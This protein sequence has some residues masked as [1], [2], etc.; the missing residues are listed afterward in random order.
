MA[1]RC[2]L[3][4]G[5]DSSDTLSSSSGSSN[6]ERSVGCDVGI[7]FV[8]ERAAALGGWRRLEFRDDGAMLVGGRLLG[9]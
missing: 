4:V 2:L 3:A 1:S 8:V 5:P 9:R 6:G 7:R